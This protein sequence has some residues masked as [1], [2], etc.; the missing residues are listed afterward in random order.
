M[1]T[2]G[3]EARI[4]Q[5]YDWLARF[6]QLVQRLGHRGGFDSLT[7]HRLL[8][9]DR[10][11]VTAADVVHERLLSAVGDLRAPRVVDAGC[12]VGGTILHLHARLGGEYDGLTL[13]PVQ[14]ARASAE[15][16]RRGL[17]AACRFHLRSYD[18]PLD[19]IAPDGANLIV[20]IE[21]LAHS[22]DPVQTIANLAAGLLPGGRLAIVD[23]VPV[24]TVADDDPDLTAF[25]TGWVCHNIANSQTL[26]AALD[27]A[28]LSIERDEDLTPLVKKRE[29]AELAP[30]I[31][32]NR[33]WR[34]LLGPTAA[35]A[36]V[37]SLHGGLMLERLYRRGL[38][39]YRFIVARRDGTRSAG[40]VRSPEL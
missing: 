25:R 2:A 18:L 27:R 24:D 20:A 22:S 3:A 16:A 29:P 7:V 12:G 26:A 37:D 38:V 1:S 39:C 31:R 32:T 8:V 15:A 9:S 10:E 6:Q 13:S 5:Y 30:M 36:L 4:A 21:S 33:R 19:A 14:H 17:S 28:G 34:L 35:G 23:D 11:G 40:K